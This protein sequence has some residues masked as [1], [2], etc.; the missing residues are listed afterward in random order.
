[1]LLWYT[2]GHSWGEYLGFPKGY[3]DAEL[4]VGVSRFWE[5]SSFGSILVYSSTALF[6]GF[7][8]FFLITSGKTGQYW[9][10]HS[11]CLISGLQYR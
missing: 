7:W 8:R 9:D 11:Y 6:A 3:A 10:L 1:M 4:S 2:G 5:S